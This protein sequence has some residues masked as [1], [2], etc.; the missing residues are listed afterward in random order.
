MKID[1]F[2]FLFFK[3]KLLP[4][5]FRLIREFTYDKM[6]EKYGEESV[7][8]TRRE[9]DGIVGKVRDVDDPKVYMHNSEIL[10]KRH[11]EIRDAFQTE[12]LEPYVRKTH[13]FSQF[14][15]GR[16]V[17]SHAK[18]AAKDTG[19]KIWCQILPAAKPTG[20]RMVRVV[21]VVVVV[22]GLL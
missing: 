16:K 19:G 20:H 15:L 13:G 2:L 8:V 22:G 7:L 11:P 3:K 5:P 12:R 17:R 9:E 14:F 18:K 6:L 1:N 4:S 10:L 21:V